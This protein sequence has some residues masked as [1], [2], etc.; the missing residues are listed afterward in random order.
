MF[1]VAEFSLR[2]PFVPP[3][4]QPYFPNIPWKPLIPPTHPHDGGVGLG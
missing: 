2:A 3:V 1:P 4:L